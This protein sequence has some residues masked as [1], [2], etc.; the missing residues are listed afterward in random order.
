[1]PHWKKD[2]E[3][4]LDLAG[5]TC[6]VNLD[7]AQFAIVQA[8]RRDNPGKTF[9]EALLACFFMGLEQLGLTYDPRRRKI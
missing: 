3:T 8:F 9:H 4:G 5:F 6:R 7:R 1:M 2:E